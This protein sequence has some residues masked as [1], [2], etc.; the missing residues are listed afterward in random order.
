MS[1]TENFIQTLIKGLSDKPN[2]VN[3]FLW[4]E[5]SK[6]MNSTYT[7]NYKRIEKNS[8]RNLLTTQYV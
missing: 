6:T 7:E 2:C 4:L 5:Y 8:K 3:N 1:K